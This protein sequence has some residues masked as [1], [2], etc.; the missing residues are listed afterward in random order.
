MSDL[1]VKQENELAIFNS[2]EFGDIRVVMRDGEPWFVASDVA[3]VLG[4]ANPSVAVNQHCK[5]AIKTA[6]NANHVDGSTPPVNVNLIPESDLYRL[7]MRS[8]VPKAEEFQTWVC[9]DILPTL[10][11]TGSYTLPVSQPLSVS[12]SLED[13]LKAARFIFASHNIV[14]EPLTLAL[15]AYFSA[16]TGRSALKQ[17][18]ISIVPAKQDLPLNVTQIG[19]LLK[20]EIKAEKVNLLLEELGLQ[21]HEG[22]KP[23]RYWKPTAEGLKMGAVIEYTGRKHNTNSTPVTQ[24]KWLSSIA[25]VLQHYIDSKSGKAVEQ[26]KITEEE[27]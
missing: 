25:D 9:E 17:G 3:K 18:N 19:L 11:K 4:Y 20:P 10:R 2:P 1:N 24:V 14:D 26:T 5:K 22:V 15:D 16:E 6:F 12:Y 8:N 13:Q 23:K 21:T 27:N 7:V